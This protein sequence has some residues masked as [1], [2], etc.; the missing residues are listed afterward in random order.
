MSVTINPVWDLND[1]GHVPVNPDG[2]VTF[3]G[4]VGD[5]ALPGDYV[6]LLQKTDGLGTKDKQA[7][8]VAHF[9]KG[10]VILELEWLGELANAMSVTWGY[11]D[12]LDHDLPLVPEGYIFIGRAFPHYEDAT[13]GDFDVLLCC[14]PDHH[15]RG[16][17]FAWPRSADPW[18]EGDNRHGLGFVADSFSDFMNTLAAREDL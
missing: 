9:A 15:D 6:E 3:K 12:A 14:L 2:T 10:A 16:K 17:V 18:M 1:P 5:V 4:P 11:F 8:F 13:K 7:W